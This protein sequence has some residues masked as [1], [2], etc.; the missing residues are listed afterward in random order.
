MR[1]LLMVVT[2]L[3]TLGITRFISAQHTVQNI[4]KEALQQVESNLLS[5][6]GLNRRPKVNRKNIQIPKAM[7][8]LYK[9]QTGQ[10]VDTSML[11]LPGRHTRSANTVR[12]FTHQGRAIFIS[13]STC[14]QN[15]WQHCSIYL[16]NSSGYP[17]LLIRFSLTWTIPYQLVQIFLS[18]FRCW[19]IKLVS[20]LSTYVYIYLFYKM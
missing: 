20:V 17:L 6:F 12:T 15:N 5:L 18:W 7:L 4:N 1:S 9:L 16:K 3:A 8:D 11:P 19:I 2:V 14:S 10:D 13:L